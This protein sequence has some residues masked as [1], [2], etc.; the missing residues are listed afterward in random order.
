[1]PWESKVTKHYKHK[2]ILGELHCT[3]KIASNLK[4]EFKYIQEKFSK[5]NFPLRFINN[6]VAQINNKDKDLHAA[7]IL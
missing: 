7:C 5:T 2:I 1:M 4:K 6:L 3:K